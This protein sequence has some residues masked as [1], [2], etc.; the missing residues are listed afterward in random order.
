MYDLENK[1]IA[2]VDKENPIGKFHK[3]GKFHFDL[4]I[5]GEFD[6][7]NS[8]K[9]SIK[10]LSFD[11][12]I[13]LKEIFI[14]YSNAP[15]FFIYDSWL[16]NQIEEYM[17]LHFVRAKYLE[18][19]KSIKE[20]YTKW[21]TSK[22]RNE[23]EYFANLTINFIERDVYKHNFFKIIIEAILYTYHAPFFNPSKASELF[24]NATD[25]ISASRMND[26]VKSELNYIVKLFSGYLAI[27]DNDFQIANIAFKEALD[28]K[29][30][31]GITAKFYLALTEVQNEQVD[32][33][34]YYLK[35]VLDYDFHRLSIAIAA[36]N[37][38]MLGYF[39]KNAFFYNVFY[40]KEFA[41]ILN[42][43]ESLLH[44][45]R[46]DEGNILKVIEE[47]V[48]GIKKKELENLV[49]DEISNSI[50]S[51]EKI[52]QN[53]S[54]S[55][56]TFILGLS[57]AFAKKYDSIFDGI[58]KNKRNKFYSEI[59]QSMIAFEEIIKE[60]I[61]A[62]NHIQIELDN[63]RTRHGE[64]LKN[65]LSELDEEMNYNI[66]FLEERASSLPNIDRYNTQK[67]MS[68]NMTYN[69]IIALVVF[70]IAGFS[71]Y[72][73]R[74]VADANE[75]NSI[76]GMILFEGAKWGIISFFIGG[77]IS[78][79]ISGLVMIERAD[80]KQKIARK[81]MTLK[82]QKGRRIHEIKTEFDA[83]EKLMADNFNSSLSVYNEKIENLTKDKEIKKKVLGDEAEKL[84]QEF[85]EYLRK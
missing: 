14:P 19:H 41:F 72:S 46:R 37:H 48:Q 58:I 71:S 75:Y 3:S 50:L 81:I 73:N 28:A 5:K 78:I 36:N 6:Y 42:I 34:E 10:I 25:L 70:L 18:L 43:I 52:I 51:L 11:V 27:K 8:I 64:T 83:K 21:V 23:K 12:P 74:M 2:A 66:S 32:V 61:T 16:L 68:V 31:G 22:N 65:R 17:K 24:R 26:N 29:K 15:V 40:E 45:Y 79:I 38:G 55:E 60:N 85:T 54:N 39:L 7:I 56:N 62:K 4:N 33:C 80:E 1:N 30:I 67:T 76:L 59:N 57:N 20:N 63:F 13:E 77:L 44:S 84:I 69:I 82:N 49:T 9:E 53:H 35:E 47:K